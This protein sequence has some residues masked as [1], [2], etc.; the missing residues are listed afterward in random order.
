MH[1]ICYIY[2]VNIKKL[3]MNK[4]EKLNDVITKVMNSFR[5]C[6][7]IYN[8]GI[9]SQEQ[10]TS[11]KNLCQNHVDIC[12]MLY[13]TLKP[14]FLGIFLL[15]KWKQL[16]KF[17]NVCIYTISELKTMIYNIQAEYDKIAEYEELRETM[18]V[19]AQIEHELASDFK[20]MDIKK[21]EEYRE[22]RDI[23]FK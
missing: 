13:H 11:F 22:S 9:E 8:G 12:N 7:K 15:Y 1:S 5:F 3:Y 16:K 6:Q 20:E 19:K 4:N 14:S 18:T 23:G 2:N 10:F 21:N 17:K